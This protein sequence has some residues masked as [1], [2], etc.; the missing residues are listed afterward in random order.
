MFCSIVRSVIVCLSTRSTPPMRPRGD[1]LRRLEQVPVLIF[2]RNTKHN[3]ALHL[4]YVL[5]LV[6]CNTTRIHPVI[7]G[8]SYV[9]NEVN[10][11]MCVVCMHLCKL[12][13]LCLHKKRLVDGVTSAI[14]APESRCV[15]AIGITCINV[16]IFT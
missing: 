14:Y 11:V 13:H 15:N 7:Y 16:Y 10:L 8:N 6:L 12:Y 1:T 3:G 4:H 5:K 2:E 9:G